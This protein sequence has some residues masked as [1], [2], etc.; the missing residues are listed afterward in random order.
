MNVCKT[1]RQADVSRES[2]GWMGWRCLADARASSGRGTSVIITA[3]G[4]AGPWVALSQLILGNFVNIA[5]EYKLCM[6]IDM[7]KVFLTYFHM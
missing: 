1:W 4:G 7:I 6:I 2:N 3:L 5:A